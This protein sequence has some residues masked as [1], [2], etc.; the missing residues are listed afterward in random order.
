[1]RAA[2][3]TTPH[4]MDDGSRRGGIFAKI[5]H[6]SELIKTTAAGASEV[7]VDKDLRRHATLSSSFSHVPRML[8]CD[9]VQ[10]AR[11]SEA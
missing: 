7:L 2:S 9:Q 5:A 6:A 8:S 11:P 4:N 3:A 1:M 10:V